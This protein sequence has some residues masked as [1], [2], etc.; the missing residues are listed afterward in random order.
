MV[1]LLQPIQF[2]RMKLLKHIARQ[3][4]ALLTVVVFISSTTGFTLYK[5]VCEHDGEYYSLTV[6]D[7]CCE[8]EV[9]E[10]AP[11]CC[12]TEAPVACSTDKES[13][14]CCEDDHSYFK[15][16]SHFIQSNVK[17]DTQECVQQPVILKTSDLEEEKEQ[18]F[19]PANFNTHKKKP[20]KR[21][22]QLY[23]RVKLD[24]PLI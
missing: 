8:E 20:D 21:K 3:L 4:V 24:P 1:L 13:T 16:S 18:L 6:I 15:L 5:H 23:N 9:V 22:Y 10:V 14:D 12:E 11:G 17:D 19:I 2:I 7:D